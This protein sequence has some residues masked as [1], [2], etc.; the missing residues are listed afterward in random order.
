MST[1]SEIK[2][3]NNIDIN[4]TLNETDF[5]TEKSK[6]V[7][8]TPE[9]ILEIKKSKFDELV[10]WLT[11]WGFTVYDKT[12]ENKIPGIEFQ[13]EIQPQVPYLSGLC[14]P[15]YVEFQ[16][17]LEDGLIIRTTFELD[18]NI[19]IFL[20]NQNRAK[21]LE[22]TYIEID[23]LVLPLKVSIIREH[24]FLKLYKI[25]FISKLDKPFF[26]DCITDLMNS[27]AIIIGK[28]DEKYY[29]TRPT[30]KKMNIDKKIDDPEL[31]KILR[32]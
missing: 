23:Q 18:K 11:K 8:V 21:E 5:V 1:S 17:N 15:F 26:F 3:D 2:S 14:T 12:K 31:E 28:W 13:A 29:Q 27:M 25:V 30:E 9:S 10:N 19:E 16:D 24:P 4:Q 7:D 32:K 20:N 22:L 6:I